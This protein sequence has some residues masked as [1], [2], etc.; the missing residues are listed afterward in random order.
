MMI[1]YGFAEMQIGQVKFTIEPTFKNLCKFSRGDIEK[2]VTYMRSRYDICTSFIS[3]LN[4]L[5]RFTT[6]SIKEFLMPQ[7]KIKNGK[8]ALSNER[9]FR[10]CKDIISLAEHCVLHGVVGKTDFIPNKQSKDDGKS[11][12]VYDFIN[13][14]QD[15]RGLNRSREEALNMSMTEY[16]DA[17]RTA[18]PDAFKGMHVEED[19]HAQ[20]FYKKHLSMMKGKGLS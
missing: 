6:P 20:E 7:V 13:S 15:K 18:F 12:N 5:D 16:I 14:A 8:L 3:A 19:S 17:M 4:L 9:E 2:E 11:L 10:F 1:D